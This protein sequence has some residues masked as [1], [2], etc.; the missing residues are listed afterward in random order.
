MRYAVNKLEYTYTSANLLHS[1]THRS[2][3]F[4]AKVWRV[5]RKGDIDLLMESIVLKSAEAAREWLRFTGGDY[6]E[7]SAQTDHQ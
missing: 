6:E 3:G 1:I 4:V 2:D 7:P 5:D